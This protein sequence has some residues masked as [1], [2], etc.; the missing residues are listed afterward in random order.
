MSDARFFN[1]KPLAFQ[2]DRIGLTAELVIIDVLL[3]LGQSG[4]AAAMAGQLLPM[5]APAFQRA[6]LEDLVPSRP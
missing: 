5:G 2:A 6:R 4:E 3:S 1:P